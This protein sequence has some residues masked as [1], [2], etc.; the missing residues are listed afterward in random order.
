MRLNPFNGEVYSRWEITERNKPKPKKY[1]EDGNE[2]EEEEPDEEDENAPKK[3]DEKILVQRAEDYPDFIEEALNHYSKGIKG[4]ESERGPLS[5]LFN[6]MYNHQY[7]KFD[8][9]GLTPDEVADAVE[10]KIRPDETIPLRPVAKILE[11]GADFKS[12]LTDPLFEDQPEGVLPR[13]WSL[14]K[15]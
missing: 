9:S 10:W 11:N 1:D 12:L 5:D 6:H 4:G 8:V 3:I 13:Q 7:F 15:Q 2:I 14:W